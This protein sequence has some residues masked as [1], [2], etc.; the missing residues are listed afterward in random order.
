MKRLMLC[1]LTVIFL[2]PNVELKAQDSASDAPYLYYYDETVRAFVVERADGTDRHL[3][4][5]GL[6]KL[7]EPDPSDP[8]SVD[9]VG[10]MVDGPGWS[11]SGD[12]FAWTAT[13]RV[14]AGLPPT[15]DTPHVVSV[16]G[17][18]RVTVLDD[19]MSAEMAW[20][21]NSDVLF[22]VETYFEEIT[23]VGGEDS[24]FD[25]RIHRR[26]MI[27][28]PTTDSLK[29]VHE[30]SY[31]RT[32]FELTPVKIKWVD[33]NRIMVE[34]EIVD[35]SYEPAHRTVL[36]LFDLEQQL[37]EM[38]GFTLFLEVPFPSGRVSYAVGEGL[39]VKDWLTEETILVEYEWER[40]PI[41]YD[42]PRITWSGDIGL[43]LR[44][45]I[46]IVSLADK[47]ITKF[48]SDLS[49]EGSNWWSPDGNYVMVSDVNTLYFIDVDKGTSLPFVQLNYAP[50]WQWFDNETAFIP[51]HDSLYEFNTVSQTLTEV[52]VGDS[53]SDSNFAFSLDKQQVAYIR[54]GVVISDLVSGDEI[55]IRPD[56]AS[57]Q[58]F[59]GGEIY[60]HEDGEWLIVMENAVTAGESVRFMGVVKRDGTMRR[61][62]GGIVV[63]TDVTIGW[64]PD[65]VDLSIIPEAAAPTEYNGL[66]TVI[67]GNHW[68]YRISWG[69]DDLLA[70]WWDKLTVWNLTTQT[71]ILQIE[72]DDFGH[73]IVWHDNEAVV[74]GTLFPCP[75]IA[76]YRTMGCTL[77]GEYIV[78][79]DLSQS[80]EGFVYHVPTEQRL[81][82]IVITTDWISSLS[83]TPD[84]KYLAI[85]LAYDNTPIWNLETCELV[86]T[87]PDPAP[88]VAFSPDG[89]YLALG[90][91]WDIQIWDVEALLGD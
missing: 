17:S 20:A 91:S 27:V 56:A 8:T 84:Q 13:P 72:L 76:A 90:V 41:S 48:S 69:S 82:D 45:F 18:Q 5:E 66:Q 83:V 3:L 40:L 51:Y 64:L 2:L 86:L 31:E 79:R 74:E 81:C 87:M 1:F 54:D 10:F 9:Y 71:A 28:D 43:I 52:D 26:F 85:G 60:W 77:D 12:W 39:M 7:P 23:D 24:E 73:Q 19:V 78:A 22:V 53:V 34:D 14:R 15:V 33:D 61:D 21:P 38:S 11:P 16:D 42:R 63:P 35:S 36:R 68:H 50:S 30:I 55:S 65:H 6:M 44:P 89:K 62:L 80:E 29:T 46:G 32:Y 4:G 49:M 25:G 70:S 58:T 67:E 57:A 59:P 37:K 75:E 88:G 47:S